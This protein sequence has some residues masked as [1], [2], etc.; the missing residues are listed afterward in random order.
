MN[1]RRLLLVVL[2]AGSQG[3]ARVVTSGLHQGCSGSQ[4]C[5]GSPQLSPAEPAD[6][7]AG[8]QLAVRNFPV[9][10][11]A[12][13]LPS[14]QRRRLLPKPVTRRSQVTGGPPGAEICHTLPP[15]DALLL[16][17]FTS[18]P[19]GREPPW[20]QT[21]PLETTQNVLE[22]GCGHL[23]TC[24]STG[25]N[26]VLPPDDRGHESQGAGTDP[27]TTPSQLKTRDDRL[28]CT[29]ALG[30][31][32]RGT[33]GFPPHVLAAG[34]VATSASRSGKRD[35]PWGDTMRICDISTVARVTWP[36]SD[37][38]CP[39]VAA[40]LL[41][42]AA[43]A[44]RLLGLLPLPHRVLPIL[45]DAQHRDT[46]DNH[47]PPRPPGSPSRSASTS[48]KPCP[49][50][51]SHVVTCMHPVRV[52]VLL[53][54]SLCGAVTLRLEELI[55]KTRRTWRPGERTRRDERKDQ[56]LFLPAYRM[57]APVCPLLSRTTYC[58]FQ[59]PTPLRVHIRS[60]GG[61]TGTKRP[62]ALASDRT[63]LSLPRGPASALP[64]HSR[65][66]PSRGAGP[67]GRPVSRGHSNTPSSHQ[68]SDSHAGGGPLPGDT[69]GQPRVLRVSELCLP[70]DRSF[71]ETSQSSRPD[72]W[73]QTRQMGSGTAE[74]EDPGY[75]S[76]CP[77]GQPPRDRQV[78]EG[79]H[80][81]TSQNLSPF[82]PEADQT[83]AAPP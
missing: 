25:G 43:L 27:R 14:A 4:L 52:A 19:G 16:G 64:Q 13:T 22:G 83:A 67:G 15:S 47:R 3:S 40:A 2:A 72:R 9:E 37:H 34:P 69:P 49:L 45:Q 55:I 31:L 58:A 68:D 26:L 33:R 18:F 65:G 62:P 50:P 81:R 1:H 57:P 41:M 17:V 79:Q 42:G 70:Q 29:L 10:K 8:P 7:C 21:G 39:Q 71:G 24:H 61:C 54:T 38:T 56:W 63:P 35:P 20:S 28:L 66:V 48:E 44:A 73:A 75:A 60:P 51:I 78:D 77:G 59:G 74:R 11:L 5:P 82:F 46:P 76:L 36:Q 6:R 80:P 12:P 32:P 30:L 53:C 23:A